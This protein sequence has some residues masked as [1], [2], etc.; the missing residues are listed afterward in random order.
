MMVLDPVNII[1]RKLTHLP[2]LKHHRLILEADS[3]TAG[4]RILQMLD[5]SGQQAREL[6]IHP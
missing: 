5:K 4:Q 1:Q 3:P 6:M 2:N